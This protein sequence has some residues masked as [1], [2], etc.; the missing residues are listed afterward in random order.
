MLFSALPQDG[1]KLLSLGRAHL[2][3]EVALQGPLSSVPASGV[4]FPHAVLFWARP[5][6]SLW[7][8]RSHLTRVHFPHA[9]HSPESFLCKTSSPFHDSAGQGLY[10]NLPDEKTEAHK[11]FLFPGSGREAQFKPK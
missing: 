10:L 3:G 9:K 6:P 4:P 2:W 8:V 11:R 1:L 5:S 7:E